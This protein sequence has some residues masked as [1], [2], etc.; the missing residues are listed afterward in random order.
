MGEI[1]TGGGAAI[2]G[3]AD[4]GGDL[5]GLLAPPKVAQA[6]RDQEI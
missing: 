4:A 6:T 1:N 3:N 2:S 5:I